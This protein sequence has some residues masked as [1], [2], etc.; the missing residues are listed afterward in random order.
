MHRHLAIG[1]RRPFSADALNGFDLAVRA[2]DALGQD[3]E[4]ALAALFLRRGGAHLQR[5]VGPGHGLVL[6]RRRLRHDF[7][8]GYGHRALTVRRAD[9]VR[10]GIAAAND[11]NV[12][13][14]GRQGACGRGNGLVIAGHAAVLLA[15]EVHGEMHAFEFAA[16]NLK[17]AG[18]LGTAGQNQQIIIIE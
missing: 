6:A 11:D 10:S 14:L 8:L 18:P 15:E 7:K 2:D 13:A 3:R 16:W 12:L 1:T 9:A 4:V 5:P 17:V